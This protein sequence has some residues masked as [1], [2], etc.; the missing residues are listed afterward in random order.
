MPQECCRQQLLIHS[1]WI[2]PGGLSAQKRE[3]CWQPAE[4]A[5]LHLK[6]GRW[7]FSQGCSLAPTLCPFPRR[8]DLCFLCSL[9]SGCLGCCVPGMVADLGE[10][11][12]L[13]QKTNL[14]KSSL[15]L[16]LVGLS[17][18]LCPLSI[19]R[20]SH[21]HLGKKEKDPGKASSMLRC[22]GGLCAHGEGKEAFPLEPFNPQVEMPLGQRELAE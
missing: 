8:K 1:C 4:E 7:D 15:N 21:R 12:M 16:A 19:Y 22:P 6:G 13:D 11:W 17:S 14:Y 20:A 18:C 2:C 9:T 5:L 3:E 10:G